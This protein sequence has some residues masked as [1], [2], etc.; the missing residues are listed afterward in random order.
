MKIYKET[1]A[2]PIFPHTMG[3]HGEQLVCYENGVQY[4]PAYD[5]FPAWR[6][7]PKNMGYGFGDQ[8]DR[9]V[10][11]ADG[12]HTLIFTSLGTKG[13]LLKTPHQLIREVNR[14]Y[15]CA[16]AYEYPAVFYQTANRTFLIHCPQEYCRLELEDVETGELITWHKG[17]KPGD[18]FHSR[19]EISPGGRYLISKGWVWHPLDVVAWYDLHACLHNPLLL[20]RVDNIRLKQHPEDKDVDKEY[21]YD[22]EFSTASFVTDQLLIAV[23]TN[24]NTKIMC[25]DMDTKK[26]VNKIEVSQQLGNLLAIDEDW[27]WDLFQH[28]KLINLQTGELTWQDKDIFSGAQNSSIIGNTD[29]P[30]IAWNSTTQKLAIAGEQ[31]VDV[32]TVIGE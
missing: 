6:E 14:S 27:A 4:Y 19:L 24:E 30:A 22:Y 9:S 15:Y 29:L 10:S 28:P 32:L 26:V 7:M 17:R 25:W 13:L 1:I 5:A 2:L 20:D 31:K 18:M 16:D 23:A 3:W 11:S 12:K 21:G 8:F